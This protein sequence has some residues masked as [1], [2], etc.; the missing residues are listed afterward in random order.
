LPLALIL[1]TFEI[2][3]DKWERP[4]VIEAGIFRNSIPVVSQGTSESLPFSMTIE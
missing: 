4:A 1:K 2:C 3:R